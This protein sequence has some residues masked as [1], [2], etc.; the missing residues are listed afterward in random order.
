MKKTLIAVAT[1]AILGTGAYYGISKGAN[2]VVEEQLTTFIN[3]NKNKPIRIKQLEMAAPVQS[4]NLTITSVEENKVRSIFSLKLA[5]ETEALEIPL[6]SEII[7][8]ETEYNGKSYGFGKIV[9]HPDLSQ[10]K[11]LPEGINNETLTSTQYIA[12]DGE[13]TSVDS[14]E[15]ITLKDDSDKSAINFG[16]LV[17]TTSFSALNSSEIDSQINMKKLLISD[18]LKAEDLEVSPINLTIK[19]DDKGNYVGNSEAFS[20]QLINQKSKQAE[21]NIKV[22]TGDYTGSYHY[23]DGL[24][25]PISHGKAKFENV[26]IDNVMSGENQLNNI[27]FVGG[28]YEADNNLLDIKGSF[29]TEV[30]AEKFKASKLSQLTKKVNVVPTFFGIEYSLSNFNHDFINTYYEAISNLKSGAEE[31]PQETTDQLISNF[32]K[33]DGSFSLAADVKTEDGDIDANMSLALSEKGKQLSP[34][35]L[36]TAIKK[37]SPAS[38]N[39]LKAEAHAKIDSKLADKTELSMMLQM[40]LGIQPKDN[41]YVIDAEV[42]DGHVN[43]NGQPMM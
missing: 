4:A 12:L 36:S 2:N 8:G 16:G 11:E 13:I 28:L 42:K 25:P 18:Y 32:Q 27:E 43:V 5:G 39:L 38:L 6:N 35:E 31:I 21:T 14:I 30:D 3:T 40:M 9:T 7:R 33:S 15:S 37:G 20:L 17:A 29:S 19:I 1:A 34:Q 26:V 22:S 10:F 24:T 41:Q 23:I